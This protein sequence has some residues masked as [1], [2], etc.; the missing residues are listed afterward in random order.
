MRRIFAAFALTLLAVSGLAG[1]GLAGSGLALSSAAAESQPQGPVLLRT[2]VVVEGPVLHLGDLFEGLGEKDAIPIARA[3]AP[4]KRTQVNARW[5]AAVAQAYGVPWRPISR[6]DAAVIERASVVIETRQLEGAALDAL[7]ERG[8]GGQISLVLDNP[9]MRLHL[10]SDVAPTLL[11]AGLS[12]DP[13]TGRFTAHLVAPAEGT[14]LVRLTLTG[15]AIEM[16]EVP[17][18]RRRMG[19]RDIIHGRDV[20]WISLRADRIARNAVRDVANLVGKSPRRPI[21]AGAAVLS[22]DLREPILVPR[23]SLVTIRL[24]TAR[25][26]LT[27]QGRAMEPGAKGDVIRVMNTNTSKIIRASVADSGAVEVIPGGLSAAE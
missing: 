27:A 18:L 8:V 3:P 22:N 12:H 4:G 24:Q 23:N 1:S 25:M 5:L 9:A 6:L 21:R 10:P 16:I 2:R 11:V 14:P 13:K 26:I 19:P 17:T 7:R 20:E 15:R